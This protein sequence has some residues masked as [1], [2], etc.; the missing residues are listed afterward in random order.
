MLHGAGRLHVRT[1]QMPWP[2]A[3]RTLPHLILS[4]L[5]VVAGQLAP[6]PVSAPAGQQDNENKIYAYDIAKIYLY[7]PIYLYYIATI[8]IS[9][10]MFII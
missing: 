4:F 9:K 7:I 6:V 1:Q 10:Y 3:D 8:Y 5:C 2:P